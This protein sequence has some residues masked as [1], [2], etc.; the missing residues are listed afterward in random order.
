MGWLGVDLVGIGLG[1][2]GGI[3]ADNGRKWRGYALLTV[4]LGLCA[5]TSIGVLLGWP[6]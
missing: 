5:V 3:M 2:W 6:L 4:G 1:G